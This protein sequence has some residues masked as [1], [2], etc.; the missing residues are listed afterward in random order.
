MRS[1]ISTLQHLREP[2][3][4]PDQ[5]LNNLKRR[6]RALTERVCQTVRIVRIPIAHHARLPVHAASITAHSHPSHP[7]HASHAAVHGAVAP[8]VH[9][10]AHTAKARVGRGVAAHTG[11]RG[12]GVAVLVEGGV[13]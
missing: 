8:A 9:R 7:C 4:R 12:G 6:L 13:G 1:H 3:K 11:V 2:S 5:T 10:V